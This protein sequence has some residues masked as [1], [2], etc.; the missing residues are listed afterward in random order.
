MLILFVLLLIGLI[1]SLV[2]K[3]KFDYYNFLY[4]YSVLFENLVLVVE[5]N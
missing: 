4:R 3:F 1:L 2:L 5:I